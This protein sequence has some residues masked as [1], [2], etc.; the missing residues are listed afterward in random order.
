MHTNI[1][2][3]ILCKSSSYGSM[4]LSEQNS[5]LFDQ[6]IEKVNFDSFE[7]LKLIG[8]GSFGK[9]FLVK[10][11]DDGQLFAMKVLK[12]RNLVT[13]KHL[14]YALTEVNILKTCDNPFIIKIHYSFQV[15]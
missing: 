11:K 5:L 6:S 9:I 14:K 8:T 12:K 15:I 4:L 1:S 7:L 3:D 2:E 13:K 10:K